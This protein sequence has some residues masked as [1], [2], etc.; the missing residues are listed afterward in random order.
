[1]LDNG[2]KITSVS[3]AVEKNPTDKKDYGKCP[4]MVFCFAQPQHLYVYQ[5]IL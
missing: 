4:F 1:M 3:Q 5:H 2:N